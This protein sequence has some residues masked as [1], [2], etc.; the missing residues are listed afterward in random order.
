MRIRIEV[1]PY[2]QMRYP[3]LGD[4]FADQHGA[5]IQ[6]ADLGNW[7]M[8][9]LVAM[10]EMIEAA[11]CQ[12]LGIPESVV[13]AWD[14]ANPESDDPGALEG[15]PYRDQHLMAEKFERRLAQELGVDWGEY[16]KRCAEVCAS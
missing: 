2:S 14:K 8:N 1:L 4:W 6:V 11:L 5:V 13:L 7:R 16:E 10:H 9:Y 15:A 12:H 3:T